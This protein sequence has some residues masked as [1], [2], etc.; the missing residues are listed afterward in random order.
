MTKTDTDIC[1]CIYAVP[2]TIDIE[3]PPTII[4]LSPCSG[5]VAASEAVA[6][7]CS[8][9][10]QSVGPEGALGRDLLCRCGTEDTMLYKIHLAIQSKYYN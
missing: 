9:L 7:V 6:Q 3:G 5:A 4:Y 2:V 10:S 1:I 8:P